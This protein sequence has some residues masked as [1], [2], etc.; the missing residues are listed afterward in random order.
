MIESLL[1]VTALFVAVAE[2]GLL[3]RRRARRRP[4]E[5]R[6]RELEPLIAPWL[7]RASGAGR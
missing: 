5:R 4:V 2:Y 1:I 6:L 3:M 7:E